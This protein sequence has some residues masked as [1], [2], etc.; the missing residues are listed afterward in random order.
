MFLEFDLVFYII[1][2]DFFI[3]LKFLNL[4]SKSDNFK[5]RTRPIL[6]NFNDFQKIGRIFKPWLQQQLGSLHL[7]SSH[8]KEC[9]LH[10]YARVTVFFSYNNRL[11]L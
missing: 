3:F 4:N 10:L 6:P 11:P 7:R 2:S 5:I 9:C 1:F 8:Y